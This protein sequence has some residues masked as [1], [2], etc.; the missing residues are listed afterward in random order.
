[1]DR[2]CISLG[3][4]H[5]FKNTLLTQ[6][7]YWPEES[8]KSKVAAAKKG[9][10]KNASRRSIPHAQR[11]KD[12]AEVDREAREA[13]T[14]LFPAIPPDDLKEVIRRAFD[15]VSLPFVSIR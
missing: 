4:D 15:L 12:Q 7:Q 3:I 8:H 13:I 6:H 1:M 14:D 9:G 11:R 2:A 10:S 5:S